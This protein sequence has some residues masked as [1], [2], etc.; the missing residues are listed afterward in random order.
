MSSFYDT[1]FS[2]PMAERQRIADAAGLS[3]AYVQKHTYVQNREPRFHFHNSIGLDRAS[4]GR[5]CFLDTTEGEIDWPYVLARLQ[6]LRKAGRV[7]KLKAPASQHFEAF[8]AAYPRK[9]NK[10][11][12]ARSWHA[13]ACDEVADQ[14]LTDLKRRCASEDW[15]KDLGKYIPHP[16]TYLNQRRWEEAVTLG[17]QQAGGVFAG[18]M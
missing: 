2:E 16:T 10:P 17:E 4:E 14:L 11:G 6:A 7:G 12:A 13:Q 15:R 5:L 3:L 9:V 8:W 1:F 18:V